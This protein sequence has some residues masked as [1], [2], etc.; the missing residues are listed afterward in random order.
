MGLFDRF[1]NDTDDDEPYPGVDHFMIAYMTDKGGW[2]PVD[3]FN[4]LAEPVDRQT[5]EYNNEPLEHGRYRLF[6]IKDNLKTEPPEGVGWTLNRE[7]EIKD[8]SSS[9]SDTDDELKAELRQLRNEVKEAKQSDSGED[10]SIEER[11]E[12]Q[13]AALALQMF[14]NPAFLAKHGDDVALDVA[15]IDPGGSG[16]GAELMDFEDFEDRPLAAAAYQIASLTTEEPEQVERISQSLGNSLGSFF[17]G[18]TDGLVDV[19]GGTT[20]QQATTDTTE[21]ADQ[22]SD[23]APAETVDAG[24]SSTADL[25]PGEADEQTEQLAEEIAATPAEHD[26]SETA[27]REEGPGTQSGAGA[28]ADDH[29]T[30]ALNESADGPDEPPADPEEYGQEFESDREATDTTTDDRDEDA[31]DTDAAT[32]MTPDANGHDEDADVSTPSTADDVAGGMPS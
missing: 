32:D 7:D 24:P 22:Q 2:K 1:T 11:L 13:K 14:E 30:D 17:S 4:E 29:V 3:G 16:S 9:S 21:P 23:P 26:T 20:D 18:A 19:E 31:D 6:A 15:G 28:A 27:L 8:S 12:K 10:A 25:V 5:F